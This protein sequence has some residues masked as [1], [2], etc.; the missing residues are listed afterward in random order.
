MSY[1]TPGQRVKYFQL[2]NVSI[3]RSCTWPR[4]PFIW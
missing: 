4:K 2:C 1:E 3:Y